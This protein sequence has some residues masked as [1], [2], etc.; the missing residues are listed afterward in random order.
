LG[1]SSGHSGDF[2]PD[3]AFV[4]PTTETT[5]LRTITT[6]AGEFIGDPAH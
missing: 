6:N 5:I 1:S 2:I 3:A 4:E